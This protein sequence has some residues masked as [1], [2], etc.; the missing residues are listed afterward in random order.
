[1]KSVFVF[2]MLFACALS[3]QP[4]AKADLL[5]TSG[6]L[7]RCNNQYQEG[8]GTCVKEKIPIAMTKNCQ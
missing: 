2:M 4:T 6:I 1:M 3:A 8:I 7:G 5:C